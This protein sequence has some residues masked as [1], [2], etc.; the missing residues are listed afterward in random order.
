VDPNEPPLKA[1]TIYNRVVSRTLAHGTTCAA[2]YATIHVP[3]TNLL[4][5]IC[6][7]RGQRALIGRVCMDNPSLCPEC[8]RDESVSKSVAATAATISHIRTLDP[9]GSLILPIITPRFAPSCTPAALSQLGRLAASA[10]P[11]LHIQTHI[12]ETKD[13]VAI[14]SSFFPDSESYAHVYDTAGLLTPRTILAHAIHLSAEERAL[15]RSRSATIS[16]CPASNTALSSGLCPVRTLLDEA[17]PVGLGTDVSGGYSP[18]VLEAARQACLVSRLVAYTSASAS[19][20]EKLSVEEA[21]YLATRGGAQAVRMEDRIGGFEVGMYWDAQMV[22]LG[23]AESSEDVNGPQ[24]TG[25]VDIFGW[26][27]WDEKIAKWMWTGDDRNVKAVW[28]AGRLVH[29]QVV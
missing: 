4:A 11:P 18:S 5:T 2:Y 13:E 23:P 15:I 14:V 26:E 10:S 3:A 8:Y 9:A 20:R 28:V 22:E 1:H 17:I 7:K 12:S 19:G 21:L 25:P 24:T 6:H 27:S 16:H 29:G